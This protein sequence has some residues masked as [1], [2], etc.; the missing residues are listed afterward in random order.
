M[1]DAAFDK[2]LRS[3]L[4][5]AEWELWADVVNGPPTEIPEST[6][7]QHRRM[8]RLLRDPF[9]EAR[10]RTRPLW[11]KALRAAACFLL[12]FAVA[13]GGLVAFVPS[14]RAWV[15]MVFEEWLASDMTVRFYGTGAA[16]T[17]NTWELGY[18]PEGFVE[19]TAEEIA[20]SHSFT[21]E[22]SD[23][24]RIYF[25]YMPVAEGSSFNFDN[26]HSDYSELTLN[27]QPAHLFASNQ[28]GWPSALIWFD[29][30]GEMGFQ[31]IAPVEA[32]VLLQMAGNTAPTAP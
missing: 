10:R 6:P 3:A 17:G 23:G 20:G 12:T 19:I 28:E 32:N 5:Q 18:L 21:Y 29:R 30:T 2:T 13:L 24:A 27:G 4:L 7:A 1:S 25:D 31:L 8:E 15:Q 22:N 9:G 11:K 14:A 16:E 26:E